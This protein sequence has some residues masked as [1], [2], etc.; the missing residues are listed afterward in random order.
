MCRSSL[1][2]APLFSRR[3]L[4]LSFSKRVTRCKL[5]FERPRFHN[6]VREILDRWF[7]KQ[8]TAAVTRRNVVFEADD[9]GGYA[10]VVTAAN[11]E[12]PCSA[13][14]NR[15]TA[16]IKRPSGYSCDHVP[17][18]CLLRVSYSPVTFQTWKAGRRS[19]GVS[20]DTKM[21]AI[22]G[23]NDQQLLSC[24]SLSLSLH[25]HRCC[26][27]ICGALRN[28]FLSGI[29]STFSAKSFWCSIEK[30][31]QMPK[32][33]ISENRLSSRFSRSDSRVPP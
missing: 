12:P 20:K 30:A 19:V 18:F 7:S 27:A 23:A 11:G 28:V 13:R 16:F 15:K 1:Q 2:R 17:F 32:C 6:D 5:L 25:E 14:A 9:S 3:T 26:R 24:F 21:T 22:A 33:G 31:L 10:S 8:T 29:Q 4:A